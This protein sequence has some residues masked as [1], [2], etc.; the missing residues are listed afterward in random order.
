MCDLLYLKSESTSGGVC[1]HVVARLIARCS[2]ECA[3]R[4][5]LPELVKNYYTHPLGH[6]GT[7]LLS[8]TAFAEQRAIAARAPD[9]SGR[10]STDFVFCVCGRKPAWHT[11]HLKEILALDHAFPVC[12]P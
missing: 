11:K 5:A 1:E 3:G 9:D 12:N 4:D 7:A 6:F 8:P 10:D 2:G